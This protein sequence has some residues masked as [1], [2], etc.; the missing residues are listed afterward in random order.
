MTA[1]LPPTAP[2]AR[3]RLRFAVPGS[4]KLR[5][6]DEQ[7]HAPLVSHLEELRLRVVLVAIFFF[8][9]FGV[10]YWQRDVLFDVLAR[11]LDDRWP[12]QTLGVTEPFFTSLSIAAQ[13][14]F[15][16][17]IP[18]I[19]WHAWRFTQPA[20]PVE[21]RRTIR[22]LLF[23]APAL[24]VAG[25]AFGYFLI[26]GPAIQFLLGLSPDSIEV[27]VRA[28]EYYSFV[29][30]TLLAIGAVFCF[31][32]VLLGLA[33]VGIV[34]STRLRSS[35]K[36]ALVLMVVIAALL[37]TADPVSLAIEIVPLVLLYELSILAVRLQER[38]VARAAARAATAE[39]ETEAPAP[40]AA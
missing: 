15:V 21:A 20:V 5:P 3:R 22:T 8:T 39:A 2:K 24:F 7:G 17:A 9:A 27:V 35:R 6:L 4:G 12:L 37:P 34:T 23:V 19:L 30:T 14:A 25:V 10:A 32:L 40:G 16:A 29:A 36:V 26:L 11:P 31:P 38:S 18:Y 1:G 28:K 13:V 33:R